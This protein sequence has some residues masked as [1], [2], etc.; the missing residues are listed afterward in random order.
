MVCLPDR[1]HGAALATA[2]FF[3]VVVTLLG[4][5]AMRVGTLELRLA[6]NEESRV[7]ALQAAQSLLDGLV[8]TGENIAVL[9]GAGYVQ[10]CRVGGALDRSVLA[11][12]QG[13]S[14]S[15]EQQT[16]APSQLPALP[17][18]DHAY[19]SVRR[20][21]INDQD[22]APMAALRMGDSGERFQLAAFTLMAG[23][24]RSEDGLGAAEVAEG[25]YLKVDRVDG[26]TFQ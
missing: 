7:A 22:F 19:V 18:L 16:A 13:F 10:N 9:P 24:D 25:V 12:T 3:L 2:L 14:C 4:L 20:E 21:A 17:L 15:S 5:T 8:Q 26:L 1:Q 11:S 6:L 23:Y